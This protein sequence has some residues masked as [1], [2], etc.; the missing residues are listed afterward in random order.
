MASKAIRLT[1]GIWFVFGGIS[2]PTANGW[3]REETLDYDE[4]VHLS[5]TPD[6]RAGV[7]EFEYAVR[8]LGWVGLG[9]SSSGGMRDSDV[10]TAWVRGGKVFFTDRHVGSEYE[11]PKV[12]KVNNYKL[13]SAVE[14]G[15]TTIIRFK[16]AIDTCDIDE[17][18]YITGDTIHVIYA[19]GDSDPAGDDPPYHGPVNRGS[20]SLYL[21]DPPLGEIPADPSIKKWL[22]TSNMTIPKV[23][24]TYW[25]S[26][27]KTPEVNVTHHIIGYEPYL[28]PR[29]EDYVHHLILYACSIPKELEAK[30]DSWARQDGVLCYGPDHP[31]EWMRCRLAL[32]GWAVGG[33]GETYPKNVGYVLPA[34]GKFFMME[35]HYNNPEKVTG[36]YDNSGITVFYTA[37]LRPLEMASLEIG[38]SVG[39]TQIIPA[40][41]KVFVNVGHCSSKCTA[42]AFP[43]GGIHIFSGL[44]HSH[45]IGRK[46]R[47]R[48]FRNGKELPWLLN[49][50]NYDFNFQ[51]ARVLREPVTL[52]RYLAFHLFPECYYNSSNRKSVTVGGFGT[53]E[54]MCLAFFQYYPAQKIASCLSLPNYEKLFAL[55]R[56]SNV[57]LDSK[58]G[59][60]Y[61]VSNNGKNQTLVDYL[62]Q[63][64]WS[65]FDIEGLQRLLRYD[66]HKEL[67]SN[68]DGDLILTKQYRY[69]ERET[70]DTRDSPQFIPVRMVSKEIRFTLSLWLFIGGISLPSVNAWEREAILDPEG[71]VHLA[72]TPDLDAKVIEFEYTVQTL[73]W[74]GLGFSPTGGMRDSDVITAWVKDGQIFFADRHVPVDHELPRVDDVPNYNLISAVETGTATVIRFT[75]EFDTCDLDQ[76]YFITGDT[77]RVIFAYGDADP[78]GEDPYYHGSNR[79]TKSIYLLDPPLGEIPDDPSIKEWIVTT[80]I[81]L[82]AMDTTYWCKI[83]KAPVLDTTHHV[84]G[85]KPHVKPGNE[86]YVHHLQFF[87]CNVAKEQEAMFDSWAEQEGVVCDGPDHPLEWRK[88]RS[89]L[90]DAYPENVG[91]VLPASG[92]YFMM[93]MHYDNPELVSGVQEDSGIKIYYTDVLRPL[94]MATVQV[95]AQ[96]EPTQITPAR[97]SLFYNIGHCSPS[98]TQA[99]LPT[100][101]IHVFAGILHSHWIE[102]DF[103][104]SD[105]DSVTIGGFKTTD[106]M[107]LAF[108]QYY[109]AQNIASCLSV[110]DYDAIKNLFG[111]TDLWF[112]PETYEYMVSENQTIIDYLNEFDWSGIDLESYQHL[113]RYDPHWTSCMNNDGELI[114][115][116]FHLVDLLGPDLEHRT[117]RNYTLS[118]LL[119]ICCA[120]RFYGCGSFQDFLQSFQD[121]HP[122]SETTT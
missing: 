67:C 73:G 113:L 64:D 41:Q 77:V 100:E 80:K 20:K 50:D 82:P 45:L 32:I 93:E 29:S 56:I 116:I 42:T 35:M 48:L 85:Y 37:A 18:Y 107:C 4:K 33:E 14:N 51:Q 74:I 23:D 71:K 101:G 65:H 70:L 118:L 54:E 44:L 78:E 60:E 110:P 112:N 9:F 91:Y 84:I 34:G 10:V 52:L 28:D 63:L 106:E 105:R 47:V 114:V 66:P 98:C 95:G 38:A 121:P 61:M 12:D 58:D 22:V 99:T 81:V 103:D 57:W 115:G 40:R 1:L 26:I 122:V 83:H 111:I 43:S 49:D 24:T 59:Y 79:G 36:I 75:R 97:Q 96:V 19:Y 72:W 89:L 88:C 15:S 13:V 11:V 117:K 92:T 119:Q 90:G 68:N 39:P 25:C 7:I 108:L 120:L 53:Q 3:E 30:F 8:T 62:D 16:R 86:R 21:L 6:V 87:G 55:L 46:L 17:D 109:P 31:R 102:C 5:W 76:D 2:L 69:K 27:H 104:S 94:E